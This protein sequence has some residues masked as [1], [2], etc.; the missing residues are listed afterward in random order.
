[1]ANIPE[2]LARRIPTSSK[3]AFMIAVT[4]TTE[5]GISLFHPFL[6]SSQR[7]DS[8]TVDLKPRSE[9]EIWKTNFR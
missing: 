9:K 5:K 8:P 4:Q 2:T 1:V 6:S 7:I 3:V